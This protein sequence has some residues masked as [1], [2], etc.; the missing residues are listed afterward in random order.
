[1]MVATTQLSDGGALAI[2]TPYCHRWVRRCR[3]QAG[4]P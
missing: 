3:I 2:E 1:M 4:E